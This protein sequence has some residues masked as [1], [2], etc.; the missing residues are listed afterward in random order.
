MIAVLEEWCQGNGHTRLHGMSQTDCL[1][2]LRKVTNPILGNG[3][4]D[5]KKRSVYDG[6]LE[7][8]ARLFTSYDGGELI[9]HLLRNL[10]LWAL[11][12]LD[13]VVLGE[14]LGRIFHRL[15]QDEEVEDYEMG[16]A[17]K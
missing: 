13:I 8:W 16:R 5:K 2:W 4:V 12:G 11:F 9:L 3:G 10:K 15:R 6:V 17:Y 14:C 7:Q 1:R